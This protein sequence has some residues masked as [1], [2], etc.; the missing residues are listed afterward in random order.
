M[1]M[2]HLIEHCE[3]EVLM[4][5]DAGLAMAGLTMGGPILGAAGLAGASIAG[6]RKD[7]KVVNKQ[8]EYDYAHKRRYRCANGYQMDDNGKCVKSKG[9]G[10]KIKRTIMPLDRAHRDK[11]D[12]DKFDAEIG[13]AAYPKDL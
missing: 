6:D 3:R 1:K 9:L 5:F 7:A 13:R 4:E 11:M 10:A 2:K 12:R 8:A